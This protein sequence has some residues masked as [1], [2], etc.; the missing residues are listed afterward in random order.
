MS[1]GHKEADLLA[2]TKATAGPNPASHPGSQAACDGQYTHSLTHPGSSDYSL[3]SASA[4]VPLRKPAP[5]VTH[6]EQPQL[7][8]SRPSKYS[9][10]EEPTFAYATAS[11]SHSHLPATRHCVPAA[12]HATTTAQLTQGGEELPVAPHTESSEG[13]C[14]LLRLLV[15]RRVAHSQ[16]LGGR[17][18]GGRAQPLPRGSVRWSRAKTTQN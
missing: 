9:K 1:R 6:P 5:S 18:N 15:P 11:C 16:L 17:R 3:P 2:V 7:A 8:S 4:W 14:S 10:Y 13:S 12:A